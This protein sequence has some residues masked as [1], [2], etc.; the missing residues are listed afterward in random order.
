MGTTKEEAM[1]VRDLD[2]RMPVTVVKSESLEN[3]AKLL[4]DEEIGA[5]IVFEPHGPVGVLSERDVVR[6][7]G[8]GCDL[9]ETEVCEYMTDSPVVTEEDADVG[10]AL[11]K[12]NESGIRHVVVVCGRDVTGMISIRDVAGALGSSRAGL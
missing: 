3:A 5:L 2:P 7:I 12:M 11:A 4:S 10:D 9:S 6:A 8:D 1:R